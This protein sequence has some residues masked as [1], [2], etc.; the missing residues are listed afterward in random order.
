M[1]EQFWVWWATVSD[2]IARSFRAKGLSQELIRAIA[3]H[4]AA[5]DDRLDWEF[6]PGVEAEHHFCLSGKGDPALRVIAE[7]WLRAAPKP[8]GTWEFYASRQGNPRGGLKL[9]INGFSIELDQM[10]FGIQEDEGR[11]RLHVKVFH[12]LFSKIS[13]EQLATRIA[14]IALDNTLG[15]DDVERW[16]GAIELGEGI[17]VDAV[18]L[19]SLGARVRAFAAKA[20]GDR[21]S[22]LRGTLDGAP[23]FVMINTAIKRVD[24]LLLDT[25]LE[26]MIPLANPTEEGLTTSD[27]AA[28]LDSM[29][30][31]LVERL[32]DEA[33]HIARET[34]RGRRVL[35]FHVMEGGPAAAI[36]DRWVKSHDGQARAAYACEVQFANDPQ[37]DV[38]RRWV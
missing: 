26:V 20:T 28:V 32:G 29:E 33:V 31:E 12:P 30:D 25:H 24:H 22:L 17:A 19:G 23:I 34:T 27:E 3:D 15:E 37:W 9:E 21:W 11:E 5:I 13:D 16:I 7:R 38:L 18:S 4:V 14:F 8:D 10:S 2:E 35:H 6:G 36:V 1:I